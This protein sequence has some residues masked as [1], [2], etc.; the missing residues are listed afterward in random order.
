MINWE[1][2]DHSEFPKIKSRC[3]RRGG[4]WH[5][6][7]GKTEVWIGERPKGHQLEK[8]QAGSGREAAFACTCNLGALHMGNWYGCCDFISP[9]HFHSWRKRFFILFLHLMCVVPH[10]QTFRYSMRLIAWCFLAYGPWNSFWGKSCP[11]CLEIMKSVAFRQEP[12]NTHWWKVT[13]TM[14]LQWGFFCHTK[15]LASFFE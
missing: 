11:L 12:Q 13:F 5:L 9:W 1:D 7:S 10:S 14:S 2:S 6:Q 4:P 3:L 15:F 8:E